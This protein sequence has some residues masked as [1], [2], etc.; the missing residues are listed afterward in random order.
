[1]NQWKLRSLKF[2]KQLKILGSSSFK[3]CNNLKEITFKYNSELTI[4][5]EAFAGC[6]NLDTVK[7][8]IGNSI[9][10]INWLPIISGVFDSCKKLIE[11]SQIWKKQIDSLR[12]NTENLYNEFSDVTLYVA[13]QNQ[14]GIN[15]AGLALNLPSGG[16]LKYLAGFAPTLGTT[17]TLNNGDI[18]TF[19]G[20]GSLDSTEFYF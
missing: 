3:G 16:F 5:P 14:F 2:G 11:L 6:D 1:L 8:E 7:L 17:R 13:Y 15:E 4:L 19:N 9:A 12:V 20:N 18:I 10:P